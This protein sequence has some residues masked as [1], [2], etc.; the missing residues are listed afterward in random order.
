MQAASNGGFVDECLIKLVGNFLPPTCLSLTS[1]S[2]DSLTTRL[3][4]NGLDKSQLAEKTAEYLSI[5]E[6]ILP[7][8]H[9]ALESIVRLVPQAP[10]KLGSIVIHG[11]PKKHEPKTVSIKATL[12]DR[13]GH[14][15]MFVSH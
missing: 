4:I 15:I 3:V 9:M 1:M 10:L 7:R 6:E 13:H 2:L 8:V 12:S 14:H 5:K 11:M